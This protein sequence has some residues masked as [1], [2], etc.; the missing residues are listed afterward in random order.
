MRRTRRNT[1]GA[2][3]LPDDITWRAHLPGEIFL[4]SEAFACTSTSAAFGG[5][6]LWRQFNF[7]ASLRESPVR[8]AQRQHPGQ[9]YLRLLSGAPGRIPRVGVSGGRDSQ[10]ASVLIPDRARASRPR[11]LIDRSA[12]VS[13]K[14]RGQLAG[15]CFDT[16]TAPNRDNYRGA[17]LSAACWQTTHFR[18]TA[19]SRVWASQSR[20]AARSNWPK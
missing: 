5:G 3:R 17:Q 18:F 2:Q 20:A 9:V 7:G 10:F 1:I 19:L 13:L 11:E 12:Q 16:D 14:R 6:A 15:N 8:L 4:P